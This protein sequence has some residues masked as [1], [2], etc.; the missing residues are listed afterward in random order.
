V[1]VSYR[2]L[3]DM[4][5][6]LERSPQEV[7]DRLAMLGAPVDEVVEIGEPLRDIVIAR[8]LAAEQ[9]PNADRLRLCSVDAGT[10]DPLQVVCGAPNVTAGSFYPFA[11]VGAS[12]P[13]GM[14]IRKAKIRGSESQGM[15]CSARELGL[16]RDHEGILELH[17]EFEP[18]ASFI[19]STGLDD[20]R[21]VVD[22][23]PNRPDLLSHLGIAREIAAAERLEVAL[24]ALP[25]GDPVELRVVTGAGSATA[26]VAA[27]EGK[28]DETIRVDIEDRDL[29]PRYMAVV[30]R[31]VKV[32]PSPEWLAS[33]LRAIGL[34]PISNIVD[35]TNFVLH[36]LGQPMHAFDLDR[37]H[38]RIVV[39]RARAG[40]R[41]TT[42]DGADRKLAE[43]MLVIADA[44]RPVAVA[45]VMGGAE[46]EV[47][48]DTRDIL[49][50]VA[51]FD[52]ASVRATRRAL[53]LGTDASYRF[54]RGVDPAGIGRAAARA[55]EL[56]R[57]VAGGTIVQPA[58][59]AGPEIAEPGRVRLRIGRVAQVLGATFDA[60]TIARYLS[61]LGF[62][63][64]KS[65]G[66]VLEVRVPGHRRF[67]VAREED[68][69]E[70]IARRHG[71]DAFPDDLRPFRP[72]TVPTHPLFLVE[73]RLRT[74]LTGRGLLE[75]RTA[76]FAPEQD[77]DVELLLP[78]AATESRLRRSLVPGLLRRVESNF[79]RGARSIRIFE[80][81][82]TFHATEPGALPRE[83]T[84]VA[85]ACTGHRT[86][87]H[88]TGEAEMFDVWDVKAL[89]GDI[90]DQLGLALEPGADARY[91]EP[92]LSFRV[93]A[94]HDQADNDSTISIGFAGRVPAADVDAPAWAG[95]VWVLEVPLPADGAGRTPVRFAGVPQHPAIE[96]DLALLVATDRTAADVAD[97]IRAAGGALLE[98][99]EPFDVYSGSGVPEGV[100][101]I[102]WRLRFRAADRTLTDDEVDAV[103]RKVL[104][105]LNEELGVQ[106]RA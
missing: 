17:G 87:P 22:V 63:V 32:G 57:A 95:D 29:C 97:V 68:L 9:H 24:H 75:A 69:I 98:S 65:D 90:A 33:R 10:G 14:T 73:D 50:E 55:A 85:V 46:S 61:P 106:Q 80:I 88:W 86:P 89:A 36:E 19:D 66:E 13:G 4:V 35:A 21:L 78:L 11:P 91:V 38:E 37:V 26:D 47:R 102:A 39:R 59:V 27:R 31:G 52:P 8:V 67:D 45:G 94:P 48:D 71:Y 54:E 12:L 25:G 6:G 3:K 76:A 100:R 53:G 79:A 70:E 15:L 62:A 104:T 44:E 40:E 41:I 77:G 2:W 74:L 16:G 99:L 81:G 51:V 83:V 56:I 72:S 92:G 105:R 84:T 1:N 64:E 58:V 34:R 82:T 96:R 23:T 5:P 7:A 42:L 28:Q 18:G 60:D 43:G 30:I 103:I 49:L 101:S 20:A 93:A